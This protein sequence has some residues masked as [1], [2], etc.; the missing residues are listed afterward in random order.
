MVLFSYAS[1]L[2]NIFASVMSGLCSI[3]TS[4]GGGS[5]SKEDLQLIQALLTWPSQYS[6]PGTCCVA[7]YSYSYMYIY[8]TSVNIVCFCLFTIYRTGSFT[9]GSLE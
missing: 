7:K 4:P 8:F 3:L 1:Y 6:F 9:L 5:P 2:T